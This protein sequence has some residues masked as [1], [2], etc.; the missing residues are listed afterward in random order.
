[1][2]TNSIGQNMV[3]TSSQWD[4]QPSFRLIPV[5]K[6]CPYVEGLFDPRS[7]IL[8]LISCI[9]KQSMHMIP[10]LDDDGNSMKIKH[11]GPTDRRQIKEERKALENFQ[12][13]YIIDRNEIIQMLGLLA[14]NFLDYD[15]MKILDAPEAPV[16]EGQYPLSLKDMVK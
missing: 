4:G 9:T 11:A 3:L 7:K 5:T 14:T 10:K 6:E 16:Q 12:E 8:V 13:Y 15:Y 2:T 1:M